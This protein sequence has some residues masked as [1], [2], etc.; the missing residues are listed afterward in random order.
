MNTIPSPDSSMLIVVDLQERLLPAMAE[1][2]TVIGRSRILLQGAAALGVDVLLTEQYPKGLGST[3][4]AITELLHRSA[5]TV[6]KTGFSAF[7]APAFRT[8]LASVP[9]KTLIVAGIE[10]HVCVLQTVFDAL[11]DGYKVILAADAVSSRKASDCELALKAA[12]H[13]GAQVLSVESILFMLLR[14][15]K[16]PAFKT[17]SA[18]IR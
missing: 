16:H 9:K 1:P 12:R 13:A 2:E 17:V 4:P 7:V 11:G 10:A 5:V 6:E 15:A 18:L 3:V 14:D 8:R